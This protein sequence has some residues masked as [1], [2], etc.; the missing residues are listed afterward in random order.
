MRAS[1]FE[2][3][4]LL[5]FDYSDGP[6]HGLLTVS[7]SSVEYEFRLLDRQWFNDDM[8]LMA[9]QV[10]ELS[11]VFLHSLEHI[12]VS[13]ISSS[14]MQVLRMLPDTSQ[15]P[16]EQLYALIDART[17]SSWLLV[18]DSLGSGFPLYIAPL[19]RTDR[20]DREEDALIDLARKAIRK[21]ATKL[22]GKRL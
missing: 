16:R 12:C 18:T 21:V 7:G 15:Q 11:E 14:G 10:L 3:S 6:L 17:S 4:R 8:E 5:L 22:S 1:Q 19:F 9:Y 13:T 2:I 20:A